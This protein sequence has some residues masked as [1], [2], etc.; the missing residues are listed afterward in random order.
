[1][2]TMQVSDTN[3]FQKQIWFI[4]A[5]TIGELKTKMFRKLN[6]TLTIKLAKYWEGRNQ[7][8]YLLLSILSIKPST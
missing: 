2:A 5:E 7:I 8:F 3:V 6:F 1:M 4:H